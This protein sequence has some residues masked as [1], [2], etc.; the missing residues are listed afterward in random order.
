MKHYSAYLVVLL[1]VMALF[2][3]TCAPR[4]PAASAAPTGIPP[5]SI[6][7]SE[8]IDVGGYKLRMRCIG[9]GTPTVIIDA[10]LGHPAV[11]SGSW[12]SVTSMIEQTTQIC[13]Y[14]RAGV[15][16]SDRAPE[17][18]QSHRTSQ[19]LVEDLHTLLINANVP[20]PYILVGHSIGGYN[21]LLYTNQYP[22]E[23]VGV[24]LVDSSHPD[25]DSKVAAVLPPEQPDEPEIPKAIRSDVLGFYNLL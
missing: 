22:Q 9:Q 20:A 13:L 2:T 11:E 12:H 24:V 8:K 4:T 25:Q 6:A 19:E 16:L 3:T 5:T 15:G 7:S 1:P 17:Q 21:V 18:D 23:V 10:S 14:D